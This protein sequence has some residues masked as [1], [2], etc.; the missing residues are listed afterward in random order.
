L[1]AAKMAVKGGRGVD[2]G[3][4]GGEDELS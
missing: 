2:F 3:V 4:L 1:S